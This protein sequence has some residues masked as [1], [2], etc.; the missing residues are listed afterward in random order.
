MQLGA[1]YEVHYRDASYLY[2]D[3]RKHRQISPGIVKSFGYLRRC[4]PEFI[5]LALMWKFP[6]RSP[7]RGIVIPR[8]AVLRA[9][10]LR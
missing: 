3:V 2:E 8:A 10:R 5:D 6:S 1:L 9:V 4:T 7:E